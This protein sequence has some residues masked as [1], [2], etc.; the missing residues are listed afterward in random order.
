LIKTPLGFI[1]HP[2]PEERREKLIK[3]QEGN[4]INGKKISFREDS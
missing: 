3:G 4:K 2:I 1:I